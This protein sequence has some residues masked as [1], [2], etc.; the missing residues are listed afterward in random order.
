MSAPRPD[1]DGLRYSSYWEPVLAGPAARMLRRIAASPRAYLDIGAGTGSLTLAAAGR[2]P[3][4]RIISLDASAAM[5]SVARRRVAADRAADDPGRFEWL[6]GDAA[7]I[8]LEDAS[9]DVVTSAFMLQL[10]PDR[11]RVLREVHRVLRPGGIFGLVTWIAEELVLEADDEFDEV[12]AELGLDV[13]SDGFRPPRHTD[14]EGVDEAGAELRAAGFSAVDAREDL[15]RYAWTRTGYLEFKQRFD[16]HELFESLS[17]SDRA[18]LSDAVRARWELLADDA[19]SVS[20]PL[21][22]ALARRPVE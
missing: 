2:W 3:A 13:A 19:F 1:P 22:S 15:L 21:V 12:V 4:S 18:R 14:Y 5:L 20:G 17:E 7:S 6:V 10:V 8:P 9:V 16:E 11:P